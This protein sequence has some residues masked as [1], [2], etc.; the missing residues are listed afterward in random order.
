MYL[1]QR[2]GFFNFGGDYRVGIIGGQIVFRGN[3]I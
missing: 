2:V 3:A 1:E